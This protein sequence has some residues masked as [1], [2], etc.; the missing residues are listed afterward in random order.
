MEA[1]ISKEVSAR[2]E[3]V[4]WDLLKTRYGISK[5][6]I[7]HNPFI[8]AQ[9][10]YGQYTDLVPGNTGEISGLFSLRAYPRGEGN[11]YLI[12]VYTMERP[13]TMN[14]T[15][16]LYKQPIK[17][18]EVK[19]AL[20]ARNEWEL[21]DGSK[22]M[23]P[24]FAGGGKPVTIE[25]DGK[26]QQMLVSIHQATNRIV[27]MPVSQVKA[28]LLDKEGNARGKGLYGRKFTADEAKELAEG[29]PVLLHNCKHK[30]GTLFSCYAQFDVSQ[31]QV[32][33]CHP[34][35]L[36][37]QV[38]QQVETKE[39]AKEIVKE[40]AKKTQAKPKKPKAAVEEKT[41]SKGPRL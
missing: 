3:R 17:D 12:K 4:N 40:T 23:G 16:Y 18:P 6:S 35:V 27:G 37:V 21:S 8:A 32:V 2:L 24:A 22:R 11:D 26:Q 25:L 10:A 5:E 28:I 41:I 34:V 36:R 1:S 13:K 39:S 38:E 9:L 33:P 31:K 20:L 19:A 15:L 29:K 14:D 7:V 30:D